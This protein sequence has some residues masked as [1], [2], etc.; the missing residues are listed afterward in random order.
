MEPLPEQKFYGPFFDMVKNP[1]NWK[2]KIDATVQAPSGA[3]DFML[4][5]QV[6]ERAIEFYAGGGATIEVTDVEQALGGYVTKRTVRVTAPGYY[7][8]VGS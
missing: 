2:F 1:S 4:W 6:M 7:V 3:G 5:C 8:M